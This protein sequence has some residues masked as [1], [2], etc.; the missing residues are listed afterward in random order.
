MSRKLLQ[1]AKYLTSLIQYCAKVMRAKC[2]NFVLY[3]R[4]FSKK[5]RPK[6]W[7]SFRTVSSV[8][9]LKQR[10]KIRRKF[11]TRTKIPYQRNNS[12]SRMRNII[13]DW[14]DQYRTNNI[15]FFWEN[16]RSHVDALLVAVVDVLFCI[17]LRRISILWSY[18]MTQTRKLRL[19]HVNVPA[20]QVQKSDR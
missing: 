15:P 20:R 9:S 10:T 3:L 14:A 1:V 17:S 8:I 5:I 16:N 12:A 11:E 2:A 7:A 19:C 6:I 18:S 13:V 4:D